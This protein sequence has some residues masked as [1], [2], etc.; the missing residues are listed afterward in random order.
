MIGVNGAGKTTTCAKLGHL[1][2]SN[3]KKVLLGACDTF[4]TAL[5]TSGVVGT[6]KLECVFG[7][8]EQIL[9]R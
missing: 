1:L 3:G 7:I 2:E 6:V 8:K 5:Q 9:R 4:K